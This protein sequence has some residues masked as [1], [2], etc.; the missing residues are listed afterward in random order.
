MLYCVIII[1]A[2]FQCYQCIAEELQILYLLNINDEWVT[3]WCALAW[4]NVLRVI[5]FIFKSVMEYFVTQNCSVPFVFV[6]SIC[7]CFTICAYSM[8]ITPTSTLQ[9]LMYSAGHW[10]KFIW[11]LIISYLLCNS[12]PIKNRH[13]YVKFNLCIFKSLSQH[14]WENNRLSY[15]KFIDRLGLLWC[16]DLKIYIVEE[17]SSHY[18]LIIQKTELQLH[19]NMPGGLW[20]NME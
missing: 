19:Q 7:C 12:K 11:C 9:V 20:Y 14:L 2:A 8:F 13:L 1:I 3:F 16:L 4:W 17:S 10:Y 6:F 5:T 15:V 18:C